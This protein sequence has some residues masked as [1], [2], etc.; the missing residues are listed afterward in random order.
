VDGQR[1]AALHR[2]LR[3]VAAARSDGTL[4]DEQAAPVLVGTIEL[5]V[6]RAATADKLLVRTAA[7]VFIGAAAL[8][9]FRGAAAVLVTTAAIVLR[10]GGGAVLRRRRVPAVVRTNRVPDAGL[11]A[12]G[13]GC[14]P[15]AV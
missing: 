13:G 12:L 10:T 3:A 14:Q 7:L 6:R 8:F 5:V 4:G 11:N 15:A 9:V 1:S 2:E